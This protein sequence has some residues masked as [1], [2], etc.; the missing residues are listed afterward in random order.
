MEIAKKFN[1]NLMIKLLF[2]FSCILFVLPSIIYLLRNGTVLGFDKWYCFLLND[3][4]RNMQT[5]LYLI[6]LT[7]MTTFYFFIIKRQKD[8][9]KNI[10]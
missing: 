6:I 5:F 9:F 2:A 3:S 7:I 4:N 10:K 8:M 1:I